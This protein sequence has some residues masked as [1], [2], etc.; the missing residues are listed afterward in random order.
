MEKID[1]KECN[2]DVFFAFKPIMNTRILKFMYKCVCASHS[3]VVVRLAGRVEIAIPQ[4]TVRLYCN[5]W[6]QGLR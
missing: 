1:Y 5:L 4:F 2:V 3:N 6:S